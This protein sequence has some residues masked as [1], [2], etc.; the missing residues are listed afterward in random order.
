MKILLYKS[1]HGMRG[2]KWCLR[3]S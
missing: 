3:I 1:V 2:I